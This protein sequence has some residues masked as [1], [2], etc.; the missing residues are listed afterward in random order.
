MNSI[1]FTC[2]DINGIGPEIIIRTLNKL[3]AGTSEH[4]YFVFC[5][6]RVFSHLCSIIPPSFRYCFSNSPDTAERS[7]CEVI[8]VD[9]MP[10]A[11]LSSYPSG[12]GT[13]S[14]LSGK[15]AYSALQAAYSFISSGHNGIMVTAPIS[16]YALALAGIAY[17]GHTEML[18]DWTKTEDYLMVFLSHDFNCTLMTIHEPILKVPSLI[19]EERV[20]RTLK[21][22]LRTLRSD[23]LVK[24]PRIAVLGLNPH[25]GEN[26]AIGTE[27]KTITRSLQSFKSDMLMTDTGGIIEG[28]FPA[29][30]FFARGLFRQFDITIGAYHDQILIPFKMLDQGRGVNYTAGLPIIRTSPDHGTAFD[31]AAS[32]C[33][34]ESSMISA[35]EYAVRIRSNR[36]LETI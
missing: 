8:V 23:L 7:E 20:L 28:P 36:S 35:F 31:I 15:I 27:E 1:A 30:A 12:M 32:Y 26:G 21:T 13:P 22:A 16:K 14:A 34:D 25:A 5:P 4:H 2:G 18:A 24:I 11:D 29:D 3:A 19:T 10:E 33:A 9:V 6:H 17:P